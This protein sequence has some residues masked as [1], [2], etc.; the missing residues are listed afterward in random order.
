MTKRLLS[1][2]RAYRWCTRPSCPTSPPSR[3]ALPA[4]RPPPHLTAGAVFSH[5]PLCPLSRPLPVWKGK[6]HHAAVLTLCYARA[7]FAASQTENW[8]VAGNG[9]G[10]QQSIRYLLCGWRHSIRRVQMNDRGSEL[11][12]CGYQVVLGAARGQLQECICGAGVAVELRAHCGRRQ[13]VAQPRV[14]HG[15]AL[16]GVLPGAVRSEPGAILYLTCHG[17]TWT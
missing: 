3:P 9:A 2:R 16:C 10:M 4:A 14:P 5:A 17:Y 13:R 15:N 7:A 8:L 1:I 6:T 11:C 12:G